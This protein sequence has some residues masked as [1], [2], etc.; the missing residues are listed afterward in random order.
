MEINE[1]AQGIF[2]KYIDNIS[3]AITKN[4][5]DEGFMQEVEA[6]AGITDEQRKAWREEVIGAAAKF[7]IRRQ[8]PSWENFTRLGGA[9][10]SLAEKEHESTKTSVSEGTTKEELP[11]GF[12]PDKA[13]PKT[14]N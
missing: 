12:S 14:G 6:E 1:I 3:D 13:F 4:A 7:M 10:K 11:S 8:T 5:G 2:N 9:I